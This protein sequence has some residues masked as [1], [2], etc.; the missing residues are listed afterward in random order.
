MAHLRSNSSW[1]QVSCIKSVPY[2]HVIYH[3]CSDVFLLL[4]GE[5]SRDQVIEDE[6]SQARVTG[7]SAQ[8]V[9][10]TRH[11]PLLQCSLTLTRRAVRRGTSFSGYNTQSLFCVESTGAW[12]EDVRPHGGWSGDCTEHGWN[13]ETKDVW[14]RIRR[15]TF[16]S[17][18]SWE[19]LWTHFWEDTKPPSSHWMPSSLR[20][21][22][23]AH[24]HNVLT[25]REVTLAELK[26]HKLGPFHQC[27]SS[28]CCCEISDLPAL[29]TNTKS[30][31]CS[32]RTTSDPFHPGK[33]TVSCLLEMIHVPHMGLSL[34]LTVPQPASLTKDTQ[35]AWHSDSASYIPHKPSLQAKGC[36]LLPRSWGAAGSWPWDLQALTRPTTQKMP[37]WQRDETAV[38]R[39]SWCASLEMTP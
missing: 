13:S 19:D 2:P 12:G 1:S 30:P 29:E 36:T 22:L 7:R 39:H 20:R 8:Y 15:W 3:R 28:Y 6:N 5:V 10:T 14:G 24:E 11:G 26:V 35:S 37:T 27:W 38:W 31:R 25:S 9:S 16:G 33:G 34:P 23:P 17:G 32:K 21:Q 4:Y 18:H